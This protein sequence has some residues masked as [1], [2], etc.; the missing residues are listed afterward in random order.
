LAVGIKIHQM[1]LYASLPSHGA[2][3]KAKP[4]THKCFYVNVCLFP[5]QDPMISADLI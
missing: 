4:G 2:L 5:E 3:K 1:S